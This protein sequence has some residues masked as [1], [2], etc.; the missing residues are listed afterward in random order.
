MFS[1][2]VVP[3]MEAFPAG[4]HMNKPERVTS[5]E[6]RDES[7]ML[8]DKAASKDMGME[9]ILIMLLPCFEKASI[10]ARIVHLKAVSMTLKKNVYQR[11]STA[12]SDGLFKIQRHLRQEHIRFHD[13]SNI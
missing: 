10:N 5:K 6:I 2:A 13:T 7:I 12:F 9:T 1:K 4:Q 3:L 11:N 8:L